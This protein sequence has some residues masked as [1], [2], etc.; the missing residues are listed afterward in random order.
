MNFIEVQD[1]LMINADK[2]VSIKLT[3][4]KGN[5][6]IILSTDN[7]T[8]T[9]DPNKTNILDDLL[10]SGVKLTNQFISL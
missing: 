3:N 8:F 6:K 2:I 4:I 10:R 1:N 9:L 7:D 5:Q